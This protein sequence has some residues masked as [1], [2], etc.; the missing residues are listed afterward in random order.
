MI[1]LIARICFVINVIT[2]CENVNDTIESR[3]KGRLNPNPNPIN[4][5]KEAPLANDFV[6]K[7]IIGAGLQG[8]I[9]AP[10][11][12]PN[13]NAVTNGFFNLGD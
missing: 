4:P 13:R 8:R 11:K 9:I 7:R 6:N 3:I 10:K 5:T 12:K 1:K 2:L